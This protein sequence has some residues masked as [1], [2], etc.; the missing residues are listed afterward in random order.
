VWAPGRSPGMSAM[1][2]DL[3]P[4]LRVEVGWNGVV[5]TVAVTGQL[6]FSTAS[7]LTTRLLEVA[8]AHPDRLVLEL[9]G[10]VFVDV[11]GARALDR[12]HKLLEAECP[13]IARG[14]P[15][16]SARRVSGLTG[17]RDGYPNLVAFRPRAPA[18]I[19]VRRTALS[20]APVACEPS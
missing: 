4:P 1:P 14:D 5:A 15:R 9:G 3:A 13:V 16:P 6:D 11:A 19:P 7:A 10:V 17:M 20:Y 8:A 18:F 12:T 2:H